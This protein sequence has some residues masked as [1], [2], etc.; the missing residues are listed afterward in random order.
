MREEVDSMGE[1]NKQYDGQ[2][3]DE[4]YRLV[5]IRRQAVKEGATQTIAMIDEE[6]AVLKSKVQPLELPNI[7]LE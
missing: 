5:R 7:S 1:T 4:Y 3:V 6:I 2:L